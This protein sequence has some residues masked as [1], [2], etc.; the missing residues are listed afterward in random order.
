MN[1]DAKN[2]FGATALMIAAAANGRTGTA[3]ALIKAGA[4]VNA[5]DAVTGMTPLMYAASRNGH[6][7]TVSMLIKAGA[8]INEKNKT[9]W[10]ALMKAESVGDQAMINLLE[11]HRGEGIT[12]GDMFRESIKDKFT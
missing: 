5:K 6:T 3:S 2:A 11:K 1:V 10:T 7:K 4:D 9:G 8:D 12:V